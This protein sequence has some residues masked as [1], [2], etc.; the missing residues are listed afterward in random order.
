MGVPLLT[1]PPVPTQE[2]LHLPKVN[3]GWNV[4][5]KRKK[6]NCGFSKERKLFCRSIVQ[7]P[8]EDSQGKL[9]DS[10]GVFLEQQQ[11]KEVRGERLAW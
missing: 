7:C 9:A 4:T 3:Q 11:R 6:C 8:E 1:N 5:K 2:D 10:W